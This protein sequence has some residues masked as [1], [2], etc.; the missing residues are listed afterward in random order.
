MMSTSQVAQVAHTHLEFNSIPVHC[1]FDPERT[2]GPFAGNSMVLAGDHMQLKV[3]GGE[4]IPSGMIK[5]LLS[6]EG[7]FTKKYVSPPGKPIHSGRKILT[8]FMKVELN[9]LFRAECAELRKAITE[10]RDT[11]RLHPI[12]MDFLNK[13][14]PLTANFVRENPELNFAR[15]AVTSNIERHF[16]LPSILNNIYVLTGEKVFYW[17]K[18]FSNPDVVSSKVSEMVYTDPLLGREMKQYFQRGAALETN[19]PDPK[20][21]HYNVG[22]AM[23]LINLCPTINLVN[24]TLCTLYGFVYNDEKVT[25]STNRMI[26]NATSEI[27]IPMPDYVLIEIDKTKAK[28]WP[29]SLTCIEGRFVIPLELNMK[30]EFGEKYHVTIPKSMGG[31]K[32]VTLS[33]Q[34]F[35]YE[36]ACITTAHKLQG[37][38]EKNIIINLNRR[39]GSSFAHFTIETLVV[40]ISRCKYL[41]S[42]FILPFYDD[43]PDNMSDEDY[44]ISQLGYLTELS[45]DPWR[46][47]WYECWRTRPAINDIEEHWTPFDNERVLFLVTLAAHIERVKSNRNSKL[48]SDGPGKVDIWYEKAYKIL[49]AEREALFRSVLLQERA[50]PQLNTLDN[51]IQVTIFAKTLKKR[52]TKVDKEELVEE[53]KTNKDNKQKGKGSDNSKSKKGN[54]SG[55]GGKADTTS[56]LGIGIGIGSSTTPKGV[57]DKS[58]TTSR[59]SS[60]RNFGNNK[61]PPGLGTNKNSTSGQ[62]KDPASSTNLNGNNNNKGLGMHNGPHFPRPNLYQGGLNYNDAIW[63]QITRDEVLEFRR[64]LLKSFLT[65]NTRTSRRTCADFIVSCIAHR[66]HNNTLLASSFTTIS[67]WLGDEVMNFTMFMWLAIRPAQFPFVLVLNSFFYGRNVTGYD[68][69]NDQFNPNSTR[70]WTKCFKTPGTEYY[71]KHLRRDSIITF[72][73]HVPGHWYYVLIKD[74]CVHS[75]N[76]FARCSATLQRDTKFEQIMKGFWELEHLDCNIP[77]PPLTFNYH[78]NYNI[79]GGD[80]RQTDSK[81]CGASALMHAYYVIVENRIAS[82]K[83]FTF[84]FM[85]QVRSYIGVTICRH[86]QS[87]QG[88]RYLE[89]VSTAQTD[90]EILVLVDEEVNQ[91]RDFSSRAI[92][93]T[94]ENNV[95]IQ[96]DI[97]AELNAIDYEVQFGA[98]PLVNNEPSGDDIAAQQVAIDYYKSLVADIPK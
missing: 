95:R 51:L 93:W 60:G 86:G 82:Q 31:E 52:S 71:G 24:G 63:N 25:K 87:N 36:M 15:I 80:I 81:S 79:L 92:G 33:I 38:E 74:N 61:T 57:G 46:S 7:S 8:G 96:G 3:V 32:A 10:L 18:T 53:N 62:G 27:E 34:Q 98:N 50:P 22:L 69:N 13:L 59:G 44:K 14:T 40:L 65:I 64:I 88:G 77:C 4:S 23:L 28:D 6:D 85:T 42:I 5:S 20:S 97:V 1:M 11:T 76:G 90:R 54:N 72:I 19:P 45:N 94:E 67:D 26:D 12:K 49:Q 39:I 16:L 83:D 58:N 75:L 29:T 48:K 30:Q 68:E 9:Q 2:I 35:D 17:L 41:N 66:N 89:K 73:V 84:H 37:G 43:K 91:H 55:Q 21:K 56:G 47:I 70:R 78:E